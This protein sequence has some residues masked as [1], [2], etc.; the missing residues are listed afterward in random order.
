MSHSGI[1]PRLALRV[2]A[3][4]A[5]PLAVQGSVHNCLLLNL[6]SSLNEPSV[7]FGTVKGINLQTNASA[8]TSVVQA[9]GHFHPTM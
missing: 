5:V 3:G 1:S 7:G 6:V 8:T 4:V 2:S 9:H